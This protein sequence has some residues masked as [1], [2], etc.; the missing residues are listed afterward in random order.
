MCEKNRRNGFST[1]FYLHHFIEIPGRKERVELCWRGAIKSLQNGNY[2]NAVISCREGY[3]LAIPKFSMGCDGYFNQLLED[4]NSGS[5]HWH[6]EFARVEE[7]IL[8]FLLE[9]NHYDDLFSLIRQGNIFALHYFS[10][11]DNEKKLI[12]YLSEKN[13]EKSKGE[14]YCILQSISN[15]LSNEN[16]Q[17]CLKE[18]VKLLKN[19]TDPELSLFFKSYIIVAFSKLKKISKRI[20]PAIV[21]F[22]ETLK[23]EFF[24][25]LTNEDCDVLYCYYRFFCSSHFDERK[26]TEKEAALKNIAK[27]A[28]CKGETCFENNVNYAHVIASEQQNGSF[29]AD[30][31]QHAE[32]CRRLKVLSQFQHP[33]CKT[34]KIFEKEQITSEFQNNHLKSSTS[35]L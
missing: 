10:F 16:K 24:K 26:M 22:C 29:E 11:L 33:D 1:F 15:Q 27:L 34:L 7:K 31:N 30:Q 8:V 19:I 21:T 13:F 14:I 12:D 17:Y 20:D 32:L 2:V 25:F 4:Y 6:I 9:E 18:M 28:I 3:Q 23:D 35:L 5:Y